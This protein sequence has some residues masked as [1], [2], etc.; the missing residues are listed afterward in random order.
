MELKT[1]IIIEVALQPFGSKMEPGSKKNKKC[2]DFRNAFIYNK[3]K[4]KIDF[5][6]N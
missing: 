1:Y 2:I 6:N 3:F 5:F 4:K